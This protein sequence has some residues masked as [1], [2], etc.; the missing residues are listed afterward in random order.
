MLHRKSILQY[1]LIIIVFILLL[2]FFSPLSYTFKNNIE[3]PKKFEHSLNN[4]NIPFFNSPEYDPNDEPFNKSAM[5]RLII[6][7][8]I[9]V[10]IFI[11]I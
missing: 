3:I 7:L 2:N 5:I 9:L 10:P 8:L 11:I 4:L 6:E 1:T